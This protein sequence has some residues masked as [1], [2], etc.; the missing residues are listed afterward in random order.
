MR[1]LGLGATGWSIVLILVGFG[2]D[3]YADYNRR[4]QLRKWLRESAW[5]TSNSGWSL[6]ELDKNYALAVEEISGKDYK[7]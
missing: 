4:Q 1:L 7:W 6:T 5:G 2:L 3:Y